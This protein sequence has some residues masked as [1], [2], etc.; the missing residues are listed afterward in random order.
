ME[1]VERLRTYKCARMATVFKQGS[2]V[3]YESHEVHCSITHTG[4]ATTDLSIRHTRHTV[5]PTK[6]IFCSRIY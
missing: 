1:G 4:S 2:A 3:D 5:M 6:C